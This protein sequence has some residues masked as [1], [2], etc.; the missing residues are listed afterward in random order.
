MKNVFR[1]FHLVGPVAT[2][3]GRATRVIEGFAKGGGAIE[4]V[5]DGATLP[6]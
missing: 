6:N 3:F 4:L 5:A 1:F 2:N